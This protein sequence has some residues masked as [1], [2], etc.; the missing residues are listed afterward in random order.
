MPIINFKM[1][2][3]RQFNYR[4]MFYD[5]RKERLDQMKAKAEAEL[6][7]KKEGGRY[8]GLQRGFLTESRANSKMKLS[9]LKQKSTLRFIIILIAILGT[10]YLIAPDV[11]MAIWN[12]K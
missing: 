1:P 10:L 9:P 5:E 4:P 2:K 3:P 8:I 12:I 7:T 11:F 6:A